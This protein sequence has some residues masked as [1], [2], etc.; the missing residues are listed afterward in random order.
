LR[1]RAIALALCAAL[2]VL[3]GRPRQ[4]ADVAHQGCWRRAASTP[5]RS[6]RSPANLDLP[7]L[8]ADPLP[9]ARR[10]FGAQISRPDKSAEGAPLLS[11]L[12]ARR[13]VHRPKSQR[14]VGGFFCFIP[15]FTDRSYKSLSSEHPDDQFSDSR[16][17]GVVVVRQDAIHAV[18][19]LCQRSLRCCL[20]LD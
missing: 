12:S 6:T 9:A 18:T 19:P 11:M 3:I 5:S 7:V 1:L 20:E 15:G 13:N 8:A 4:D 10:A 14:H 17:A 16:P 2:F